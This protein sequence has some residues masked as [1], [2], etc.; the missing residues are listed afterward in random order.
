MYTQ[1]NCSMVKS[2]TFLFY[3]MLVGNCVTPIRMR[4]EL[5]S[6]NISEWDHTISHY[7]SF[8]PRTHP[9]IPFSNHLSLYVNV[10]LA[11]LKDVE[12]CVMQMA[13]F[14]YYTRGSHIHVACRSICNRDQE[15]WS[16]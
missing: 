12:H 9:Y 11:Y 8:I 14:T 3:S 7:P 15:S 5:L 2:H 13:W 6:S 10:R 4:I 1:N 16:V